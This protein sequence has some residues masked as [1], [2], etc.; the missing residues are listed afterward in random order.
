MKKAASFLV[1][2]RRFFLCVFLLL[3]AVSLLVMSRVRINYDLTEYLP[4]DSRMKQGI[5]LM[6]QEFG[7]ESSS[8]LRVMLS[9][10]SEGEKNEAVH[11]LSGQDHVSDVIWQP[12][13]NHNRDN[14]TLFEITTEYDSHSKEAAALF[15]AVHSRYDSRGVETGGDIHDANVPLLPLHMIVIS[16]ALVLLILLL[17]CKSWFEP[18]VIMANIGIAVAINLGT[19]IVFSGISEYTSSIVGLLQLVLSMDY[20][21]ILLNRYAQEKEKSPDNASAMKAA[22]AAAFPAVTGSSL[23]TFAGL[24]CLAFMR[25]RLGADM[26]FAL[27]KSV[28]VSLICIFTVLPSLILVSDRWIEKTRKKALHI[29]AGA[30]SRYEY[31][32]RFALLFV[33][34]ALFAGV[35]LLKS[36]TDIQYMLETSNPVDAVFEKH[37]SLVLLYETKDSDRIAEVLAPLEE[38]RKV[39]GITAFCNTL[40]KAYR[41]EEIAELFGGSTMDPALIR[42]I[43]TDRFADLPAGRDTSL[44]ALYAASRNAYR[45]DWAMMPAELVSYLQDHL[46]EDPRFSGFIT[47]DIRQQI[48][49]AGDMIHTYA[50][51]LEG[52]KTGRVILTV[53][54]PE[55]SAETRAFLRSLTERCESILEGETWLIGTAVMNDEMAQTFD[56]ELNRITL[57]SALAIFIVVALTFRSLIIPL[58]LVLT[59]QCG[60]YL[61]MTFISLSGGSMFY[62]AILMVQC[63][64]MGA[65]VDYAI[66]YTSYYR[67]QRGRA[68]NPEAIRSALGGSLHTILTSASIMIVAAGILGFVFANPA[69]GEICL[70]ISRG[71]ISASL[72]IVFILPGVLAALDRFVCRRSGSESKN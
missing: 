61:T 24:L 70:T 16:V 2:K 29:P 17:M 22:L 40:G 57:L 41:A 33:F 63:I 39:T 45:E 65:T 8:Q 60:I 5:R 1:E 21:I 47:D 27:A 19:N 53:S 46:L 14:C 48:T 67:E 42:L 34:L 56:S 37:H 55:D 11:W 15:S 31:R 30:L 9:G 54:Y 44:L 25:F 49:E 4:A 50:A 43:Y 20:S 51:K 36:G 71:A 66:L 6:E 7:R 38:D 3:A 32:G 18:V 72:I 64:L 35:F 52:E 68:G 69:I 26:G 62:L 59:V 12:D 13:E 23:T 10:L 58:I 28:I